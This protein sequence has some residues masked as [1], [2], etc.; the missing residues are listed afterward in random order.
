MQQIER[1]IFYED[2]FLGVTVGGIAFSH[3]T[4]MIDAPLRAEDARAWRSMLLNQR[5]G[6][7][8]LL[9][10]LDSHPDRT[11]GARALD[12]TILAHQKTAQVF[13]SR[14]TIFK[15]T[16]VESGSAWELYPEAIG[17]RWVTPDIT[18]THSMSLHWGGPEVILEHHPGPTPGATWAVIPA[19]KVLFV[20]DLVVINQ[21]PFLA[22]AEMEEW[23]EALDL[24]QTS[25]S[26]HLI[27]SGRGGLVMKDAIQKQH[28][29]I[30]NVLKGI[31]KLA[32]RNAAPE[33]TEEL[34]PSLL[35]DYSIDNQ[36]REFYTHRLRYGL[37][38][39]YARRYRPTSALEQPQVEDE[40]EQ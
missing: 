5:G 33:D 6:S 27:I 20:G 40:E 23:L 37:H 31:E 34:L 32:K 14:P 3:G 16:L 21:P 18:F 2:T 25:Y 11:L 12:C 29:H 39:Y 30:R 38:Q 26:D 28:Q 19:E 24:L 22:Y 15:G 1:G 8:R 17:M 36:L 4:I 10:N 13:R 35:S 7:N 9:V